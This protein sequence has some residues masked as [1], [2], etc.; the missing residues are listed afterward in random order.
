MQHA[1]EQP[2]L[3]IE[4][5][6]T[7][8]RT[9]DGV[10]KAVDGVSYD[11]GDGKTVGV[12]GESGCG[13]SITALSVM[14]LIETP[15]EIALGLQGLCEAMELARADQLGRGIKARERA[16]QHAPQRQTLPDRR[17]ECPGKHARLRR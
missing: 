3:R 1:P 10:V 13:K 7:Y 6:R 5:L 17:L 4:D 12:V 8:F 16:D 2:L 15:G 14:R 11:I 9:Q